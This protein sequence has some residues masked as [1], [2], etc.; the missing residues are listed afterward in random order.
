MSIRVVKTKKLG[1]FGDNYHLNRDTGNTSR[2][3]RRACEKEERKNNKLKNT[4]PKKKSWL[5]D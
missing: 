2:S 4:P 1:S 3:L 5:D